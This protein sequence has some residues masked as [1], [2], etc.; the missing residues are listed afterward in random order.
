MYALIF[1]IGHY[2]ITEVVAIANTEEEIR[3][4]AR[5]FISY[6]PKNIVETQSSEHILYKTF[7]K[8]YG[9]H[10]ERYSLYSTVVFKTLQD[11]FDYIER[12]L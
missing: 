5:E 11:V 12:V 4:K 9:R 6:L 8:K 3:E 10:N 7:R 2:G 1:E